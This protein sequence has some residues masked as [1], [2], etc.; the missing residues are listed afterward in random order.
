MR[1]LGV[2]RKLDNLGWIVLPIDLR[3]DLDI[4]TGDP[5]EMFVDGQDIALIKYKPTCIF[6]DEKDNLTLFKEKLICKAC[7]ETLKKL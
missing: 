3:R 1:A 4:E 5:L 7:Q 2:V 6:C